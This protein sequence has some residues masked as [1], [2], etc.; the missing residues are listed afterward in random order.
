M[1]NVKDF[2]AVGN[3]KAVDTA[4][5]QKAIDAGGTVYIP[6]GVYIIGTLYL[7]SN[8][9]LYLSPGAKLVASHNRKD[10]NKA[11]YC[12]QNQIFKNEFMAG[13]HLI[14]AVDK[15]NVFIA[16]YGTIYGDSHYWVNEKRK[17]STCSF[18][19]HPTA[20]ANRPAQMIFFAECK[21]VRVENI[22]LSYAPFWHLFF[23]GCT[24]VI[25]NAVNIKGERRQWVNDGIDIDCCSNVT[26]SNCIIDTG[27]D[28]ITLRA[29]GKPLVNKEHICE[30]VSVSNCVI[31]SYLD[32]GI[33]IGV[34][35]GIIRNCIFTNVIIQNSLFGIG[36]TCRFS[37]DG[38]CTSVENIK[39]SDMIIEAR[40]AIDLKISTM[41]SHQKL[42]ND[43]YIKNIKFNNVDATTGKC[44][45]ILGFCDSYCSDIEFNNSKLTFAPQPQDNRGK[46]AYSDMEQIRK[47]DSVLFILKS[48]NIKFNNC[49]I[50]T[51][52]Y[53]NRDIS[54]EETENITIS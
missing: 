33:R 13:T 52:N 31:T 51:N 41:Q 45:Y 12:P 3:G 15:E 23:H 25:V 21:N 14:T 20:E 32:Y 49:M 35:N 34:G 2:G 6:D 24:D 16:G 50:E 11:D 9:G 27:D 47:E 28:G 26:I 38:D 18:W 29:N 37:P 54:E 8:G 36:M 53:F 17:S 22:N 40:R 39:F 30:N 19:S 43:G 7:K 48:K 46:C 5:I 1:Q 44:C 4:A 10:Y 42:K